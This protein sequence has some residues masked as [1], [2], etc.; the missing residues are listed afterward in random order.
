MQRPKLRTLVV[1]VECVA[2]LADTRS[3]SAPHAASGR[4]GSPEVA[5]PIEIGGSRR[6]A[7]ALLLD[8]NYSSLRLFIFQNLKFTGVDKLKAETR[9]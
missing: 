3:E 7:C 8:C 9:N 5:D 1:L 6:S 4:P 2:G